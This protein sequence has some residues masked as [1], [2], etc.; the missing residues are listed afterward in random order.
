MRRSYVALFLVTVAP[1]ALYA[2][3]LVPRAIPDRTDRGP[4]R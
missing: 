4:N 2:A 1:V 3:V